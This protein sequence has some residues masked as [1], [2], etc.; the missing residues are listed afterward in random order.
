MKVR[1]IAM[2]DMKAE[3]L[4]ISVF[5]YDECFDGRWLNGHSN[6]TRVTMDFCRIMSNNNTSKRV[7]KIKK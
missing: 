6:R 4:D 3:G 5:M 2:M 7:R 1:T